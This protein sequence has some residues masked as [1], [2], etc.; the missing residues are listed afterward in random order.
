MAKLL[1]NPSQPCS[2]ARG[3]TTNIGLIPFQRI[4]KHKLIT[5]IFTHTHTIDPL[6][7][8]SPVVCHG[9]PEDKE[10]IAVIIKDL[11]K[12]LAGERLDRTSW[13]NACGLG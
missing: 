10:H 5:S 7:S 4:P 6:F 3:K 2:A 12:H 11:P 1:S 9:Q 8:M 13:A